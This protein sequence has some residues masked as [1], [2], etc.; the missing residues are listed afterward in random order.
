MDGRVPAEKGDI[1]AALRLAFAN[2]VSRRL[3]SGTLANLIDKLVLLAVQLLA[4]PLLS[5]HWGA[6]GYGTWLMLMTIPT[7]VAVSDFGLGAAAGVEITRCVARGDTAQASSVFQSAW[8]FVLAI[9]IAI[10]TLAGTYTG[11]VVI[12]GLAGSVDVAV[13]VLL[14]T[15][16]AIVAVQMNTLAI[17][18]RATHK[19]ALAM[20]MSAAV[21]AAEGLALVILVLLGGQLVEA[22]FA[23]L[24][25]RFVG[26]AVTYRLL[27][28]LEPWVT[29]GLSGADP[30]IVRRLAAP[31]FA[32]LSLAL[33]SSISLQGMILVLGWTAGPVVAGVFGAARFLARVPLQFSGLVVRASIP[34]LT[35]AQVGSDHDM[36][37]RLSRLNIV[38]AI[39]PTLP[40]IP[41]LV[42]FGPLLLGAMSAGTLSAQWWLF[43]LLGTTT[44]LGALWQA[45]AS[46]LLAANQQSRFAY[47]YVMLSVMAIG[48]VPLLGMP[49]LAAAG[50]CALAAELVLTVI[51][52]GLS[53]RMGRA[54][55]RQKPMPG[56][57][58]DAGQ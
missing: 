40:F 38:T 55:E 34:E 27:R 36:V 21:V 20:I 3:L 12:G 53:K 5:H 24:V 31:S 46:P 49:P 4:I 2:S 33:A 29:L 6:D 35:R 16:Y 47:I 39:V 52:M 58:R 44:M 37:R 22:T 11:L 45:A 54:S 30:S 48:A 43:A 10:A 13:A 7:Y 14:A 32:A 8:A 57:R 1:L 25:V 41:L 17:V 23:L 50:L 9:L 19:F 26:W 28:R 18:Y 42:L 56:E 51:V 15:L